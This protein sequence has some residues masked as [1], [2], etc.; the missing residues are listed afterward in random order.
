MNHN[1]LVGDACEHIAAAHYN[2][3]HL[4]SQLRVC[5]DLECRSNDV[6]SRVE[7]NDLAAG[8][9]VEDGLERSRI[10]RAPVTLSTLGLDADELVNCVCLVLW[11]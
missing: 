5:G 9:L 3:L 7:E 6:G 11:V 10:V 2:R 4:P 1:R 8:I